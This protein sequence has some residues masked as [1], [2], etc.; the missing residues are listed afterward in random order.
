MTALAVS[1]DGKMLA[2]GSEDHYI[3][4]SDAFT[5][6][7]LARWQA[8]EAGVTALTFSSDGATLVSGASDGTLKLWD[9]PR[10]RRGLVSLGLD[11]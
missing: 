7:E 8:H 10:I 3:V 6:A 9:L 11:W 5:R 4:L 1:P 2:S